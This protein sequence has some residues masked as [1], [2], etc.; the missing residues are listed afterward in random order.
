MITVTLFIM[1]YDPLSKR[2]LIKHFSSHF[3]SVKRQRLF[4][5]KECYAILVNLEKLQIEFINILLSLLLVLK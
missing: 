1:F 2:I 5:W 3:F 4:Q